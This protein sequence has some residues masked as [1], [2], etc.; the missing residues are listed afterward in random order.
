MSRWDWEDLE[1]ADDY[2]IAEYSIDVRSVRYMRRMLDRIIAG[3]TDQAL[4]LA[5]FVAACIGGKLIEGP[6]PDRRLPIGAR[7][8]LGYIQR[9]AGFAPVAGSPR[10]LIFDPTPRDPSLRGGRL[11]GAIGGMH[12]TSLRVLEHRGYIVID[13]ADPLHW[14]IEITPAGERWPE[15]HVRSDS[16]GAEPPTSGGEGHE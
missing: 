9:N 15:K 14:R 5:G 8:A 10:Y 13:R 6:D 1:P 11:P 2:P 12:A 4:E 7:S 16:D 3:H